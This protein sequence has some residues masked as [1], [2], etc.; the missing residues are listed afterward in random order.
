M[1]T[2]T[3]DL[4]AVKYTDLPGGMHAWQ[5]ASDFKPVPYDLVEVETL[6]GRVRAWWTGNAW[7]GLRLK[8]ED[9]IKTWKKVRELDFI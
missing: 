5:K 1:S 2:I 8:K 7:M 6:R 4:V 9:T 3:V